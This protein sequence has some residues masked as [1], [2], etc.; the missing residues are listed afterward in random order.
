MGILYSVEGLSWQATQLVAET[1]Q[2]TE[3]LFGLDYQTLFDTAMTMLVVLVLYLFLSNVLI[4][5]LQKLLDERKSILA[6][7]NEEAK[8]DLEEVERLK[9]EYNEKLNKANKEAD[10]ILSEA[11]KKSLKNEQ[12]VLDEAKGKATDILAKARKDAADEKSK[13]EEL[14]NAQVKDVASMMAEKLVTPKI[15]TTVSDSLLNETLK[16]VGDET[17]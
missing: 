11:R 3:R 6:K 15:N 17:C 12:A 2:E 14:V 4:K 9:A 16:K 5:P 1:T 8:K 10:A 13:A 7:Q